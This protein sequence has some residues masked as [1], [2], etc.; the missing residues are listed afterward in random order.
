MQTHTL[1]QKEVGVGSPQMH[2]NQAADDSLH[3]RNN[4]DGSGSS[5]LIIIKEFNS[6]NGVDLS[7]WLRIPQ[8]LILKVL[9]VKRVGGWWEVGA[10]GVSGSVPS[11]Y[12]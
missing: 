8:W 6:K 10:R 1:T 4:S 12:C 2:I 5:W 11:K 9:T 7:Q 3:L